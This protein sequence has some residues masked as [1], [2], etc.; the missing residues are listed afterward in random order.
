MKTNDTL[1]VAM[2]TCALLSVPVAG[3]TETIDESGMPLSVDGQRRTMISA[4]CDDD[5][6]DQTCGESVTVESAESK[7]DDVIDVVEFG[8]GFVLVEA[9]AAGEAKVIAKGEG[10]RFKITYRVEE[11]SSA[12]LTVD[13]VQLD[14]AAF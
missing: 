12:G 11:D 3:C 1:W 8:P 7:D 10:H 6:S 4:P 5:A 13:A 2:A 9:V 14:V